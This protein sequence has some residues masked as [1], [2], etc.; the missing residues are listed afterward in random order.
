VPASVSLATQ[1]A[2]HQRQRHEMQAE[3][4]SLRS[5]LTASRQ[6]NGSGH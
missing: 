1:Q 4:D 5:Q 2:Q 3:I 6:G